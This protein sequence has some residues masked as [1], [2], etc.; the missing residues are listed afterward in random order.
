MC[1]KTCTKWRIF[2]MF[3]ALLYGVLVAHCVRL[4]RSVGNLNDFWRRM[5]HLHEIKK[6][7]THVVFTITGMDVLNKSQVAFWKTRIHQVVPQVFLCLLSFLLG[8]CW[9]KEKIAPS[10]R[11][12]RNSCFWRSHARCG[13]NKKTTPMQHGNA[14]SDFCDTSWA[15]ASV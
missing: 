10:L 5:W 4:L 3:H 13:S 11:R 9:K 14:K 15:R 1:L 6:L 7:S 2:D 12:C 8:R